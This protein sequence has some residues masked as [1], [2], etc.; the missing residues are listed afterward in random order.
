VRRARQHHLEVLLLLLL[1]DTRHHD[2]FRVDPAGCRQSGG[3]RGS[4]A[5][6]AE[7]AGQC[8]EQQSHGLTFATWEVAV[9]NTPS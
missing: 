8:T 5:V 6:L 3:R 7:D 1:R 4:A 2:H 9:E